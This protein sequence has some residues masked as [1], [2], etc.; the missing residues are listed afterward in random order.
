MSTHLGHK[1]PYPVA[2]KVATV[3]RF[4]AL[5]RA[6]KPFFRLFPYANFGVLQSAKCFKINEMLT[7]LAISASLAG[8]AAGGFAYAAMWPTSQI[9]GYSIVAGKEPSE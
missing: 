8:L 2:L 4:E 7:E 9:F 1:P 6:K 5:N 3:A